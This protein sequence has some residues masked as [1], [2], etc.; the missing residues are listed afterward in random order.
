LNKG[1]G[2]HI[3]GTFAGSV[4]IDRKVMMTIDNYLENE[5]IKENELFQ[6]YGVLKVGSIQIKRGS[7]ETRFQ[8]TDFKHS[9]NIFYNG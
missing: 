3:I 9:L 8:I 5:S 1:S 4:F 2:I 7:L 6:I